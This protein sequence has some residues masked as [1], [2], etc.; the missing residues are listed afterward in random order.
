MGFGIIIIGITMVVFLYWLGGIWL[1][2]HETI[3]Q[4]LIRFEEE[5]E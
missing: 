5:G 3:Q 1:P 4:E 2:E